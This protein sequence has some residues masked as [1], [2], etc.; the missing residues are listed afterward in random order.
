MS[1]LR[2]LKEKLS[3]EI[4]AIPEIVQG[5]YYPALDGLRGIAVLMVILYHFGANR[6]LRPFHILINGDIGVDIF[7]VISGFLITT[8]LLKEKVQY[9][10]ISLKR[11]Y[12]RRALRIIPAAYVFLIIMI[13]LASIFK[14]RV[15]ASNF[16]ASFLFYKNLPYQEEPYMGHFWSLAAEV[17]FYLV[18]PFLLR[19]N[20]NRYLVIIGSIVLLVPLISILGYYH[21]GFLFSNQ[22]IQTLTKIIMYAFWKGP[23]II[24]IGSMFAVLLFKGLIKVEKANYFLSFILLIIAIVISSL[25]FTFYT[26]YVSECLSALLITWV[27]LLNLGKHNLLSS[28]LGSRIL[29][30]IGVISYSL[31]LWQQLF[32][33]NRLRQPWITNLHDHLPAVLILVKLVSLFIIAFASYYF[34]EL[35]FLKIKDK[36]EPGKKSKSP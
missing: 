30:K 9:G 29:V 24:L 10:R 11:F 18:F 25:S 33:G 5:S 20:V 35:K 16:L 7:F 19:L 2:N 23:F 14:Y 32:I 6:F 17:Q 28:I 26:K 22:F 27:I 31:Y 21:A 34:I 8:L 36:Y 15:S 4:T 1:Y 3:A 12:A 13:I